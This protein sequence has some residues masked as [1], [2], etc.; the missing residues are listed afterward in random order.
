MMKKSK[1]TPSPK[2]RTL[3]VLVS[4]DIMKIDNTNVTINI[5]DTNAF[6]RPQQ[7]KSQG[8]DIQDQLKQIEEE[9]RLLEEEKRKIEEA[10]KKFLED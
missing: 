10:K 9:K 8:K 2:S 1:E 4:S 6:E 5:D 7:P 3:K